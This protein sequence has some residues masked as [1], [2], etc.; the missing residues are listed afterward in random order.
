MSIPTVC[1]KCASTLDVRYERLKLKGL[2]ARNSI[3]KNND[4]HRWRGMWCYRDVLPA[5]EAV[6]LGEGWIPMLPSRRYRNVFLKEEGA[7]PTGTFKARGLSMAIS[8]LRFYGVKKVAVPFAGNAGAAVTAY[9]AA[10]GIEAHIFM[11]KD[12]PLAN[13]VESIAYGANLALVDGLISDCARIVGERKKDEGWFD[14]STLKEPFRV[15]GKK[16]MGTNWWSNSDGNTRMPSSIQPAGVLV[17]LACG[18]RL[19]RWKNLDG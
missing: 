1:E 8:M 16:T 10:A 5:V 11:P 9:S 13:Q 3:E 12:V 17:S 18:R 6:T 19:K 15:E 2:D 14:L 7:N 4:H